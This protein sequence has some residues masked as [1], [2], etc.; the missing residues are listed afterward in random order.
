MKNKDIDASQVFEIVIQLLDILEMLSYC[1]L[2]Y[3]DLKP[4]NIMLCNDRNGKLRVTLI[5]FGFAQKYVDKKNVHIQEGSIEDMFRGN[6]LFSSSHALEFFTPSRRDDV[7]S[8]GYLLTFL[9]N[10]GQIPY[11]ES[12]MS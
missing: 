3:N 4:D 10:G 2:T 8:V 9:L 11:F 1:R 7:I 12:L 6:L 5:D